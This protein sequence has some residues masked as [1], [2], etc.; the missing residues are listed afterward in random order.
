[1]ARNAS[2]W[3][4]RNAEAATGFESGK[5][6]S[7]NCLL[8]GDLRVK[9]CAMPELRL[10][11]SYGFRGMFGGRGCWGMLL[12]L[13]RGGGRGDSRQWR[14]ASRALM[15]RLDGGDGGRVQGEFRQKRPTCACA[16]LRVPPRFSMTVDD[17]R[18]QRACRVRGSAKHPQ[19]QIIN[20]KSLSSHRISKK[21]QVSAFLSHQKWP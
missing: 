1:M 7:R 10:V 12:V 14:R 15:A 3:L 4:I 5:Q 19:S 21:L 8:G 20:L 6:E 18:R 17:N 16:L 9:A 13:V 11:F 2:R